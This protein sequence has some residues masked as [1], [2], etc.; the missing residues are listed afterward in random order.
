MTTDNNDPILQLMIEYNIPLTRGDYLTL[1]FMGDPPEWSAELEDEI[2]ERF[3]DWNS[4]SFGPVAE[5]NPP[6]ATTGQ[7]PAPPKKK[8][9]FFNL[10]EEEFEDLGNWT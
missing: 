2:P 4:R 1:M 7:H 6:P 9:G 5:C 8:H 10:S 3:Q